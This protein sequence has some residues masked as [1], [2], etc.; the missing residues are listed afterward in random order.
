MNH[1]GISYNKMG[2]SGS[3]LPGL[4]NPDVSDIDFVIYGL[5]NH[6]NAWKPL[7]K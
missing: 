4:Y 7:K 2:I 1:T 3:I 5:K 6:R